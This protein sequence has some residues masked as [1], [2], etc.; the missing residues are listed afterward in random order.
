MM[1]AVPV[2]GSPSQYVKDERVS[3]NAVAGRGPVPPECLGSV[4]NQEQQRSRN[5]KQSENFHTYLRVDVGGGVQSQLRLS[6]LP[7]ASGTRR[8]GSREHGTHARW[9]L[10]H[11]L[12]YEADEHG[13]SD[14][15][16]AGVCQSP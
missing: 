10:F 15:W 8:E 5:K 6:W 11:D 12:W 16:L 13:V 4:P 2:S 3:P 7:L 9:K 1:S 14:E